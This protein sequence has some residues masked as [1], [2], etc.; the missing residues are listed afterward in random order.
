MELNNK[1]NNILKDHKDVLAQYEELIKELNVNDTINENIRLKEKTKNHE[2]ELYILRQKQSELEKEII[3]LKISLKDQMINEKR[4]IVGI[5]KQKTHIYFQDATNRNTN[6]L[7]ALEISASKR[8]NDIKDIANQEFNETNKEIIAKIG[9]IRRELELQINSRKAKYALKEEGVL[10]EIEN[11]YEKLGN[12][13]L[14]NAILEKKKKHNNLEVKIGLNWINKIGVILLL[15]GVITA[16]QYTYSNW[17]DNYMKGISGF[18]LGIVLL[19]VGE[20]FNRKEKNLFALGLIGG[21]IGILYLSVFSSYF[22][23]DIL[24][25]PVSI[26]ISVLITVVS[27]T[28]SQRYKSMTICG[29][30]LIGGYLPF[31]SYSF[32]EGLTPE[33]IY[34]SMGYLF[35]LNILV[36]SISLGRRW[37]YINY[38]SF[39]LNTICLIYLVFAAP[40]KMISI[41]YALL[42]FIMYLVI[43]LAYPIGAKV[44]LKLADIILLALNT[45]I[46]CLLVY[47]LIDIAG[48]N[49]YK[50]LLA[51]T[52]AIVYLGLGQFVYK[53]A[54]QE[55]SI[56][57]LFYITA[58]TFTI[59]V[60]P[61]QFGVKWASLGWLIEG[62][63]LITYA[64]KNKEKKIELSGWIILG[65][66]TLGFVAVDLLSLWNFEYL[67]IRYSSLTL[68]FI[69]ALSIYIKQLSDSE[70]FKYSTKGKFLTYF[71]YITVINA[72]LFLM[73]LTPQLYHKYVD[74]SQYNVFYNLISVAL[75]TG[76]FAYL[77]TKIKVIQDKVINGISIALYIFVDIIGFSMCF[78]NIGGY[79]YSSYKII[80]IVILITYNIFV[81]FNLKYL[82]F[83]LLKNRRFSIEYYPIPLAIYIL[84]SATGLVISQF[85]IG[86][87]NLIVSIFFIVMSFA[88]IVSGFKK[89]YVILRRFGLGLSIISTGKLFVF[90]L[91]F[92]ETGGKIIAYFCFGLVL[93]GISY[94]Y[95]RLRNS[96]DEKTVE[97]I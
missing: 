68:G 7:E 5:S 78:Y 85:N 86:N 19:G 71:K 95:H 49:S 82:I 56:Q 27:L 62:L 87:I 17:F 43:T 14:S 70:I 72:W 92:L 3:N 57:A 54:S 39:M 23:L 21:G 81:F 75:I 94:I 33:A 41:F 91:M 97:N 1:I 9:S 46:N 16:M 65:L 8:L 89:S 58:L 79:A 53:S 47:L 90:D 59:L 28:L 20:W 80:A 73:W 12:E 24:S 37:I 77:I 69:Y 63:L 61:F 25:M 44:K 93:I 76:L 67:L 50:G 13:E 83:K 74:I 29:I 52:Y 2:E 35:I 22:M 84:G 66:C 38:L 48:Y 6:K 60:I 55:K 34:I 96:F 18:L 64:V 15:L 88:Y 32:F 26:L 30:S 10:E 11:E 31:F 36:L 42:T 40:N 45:F 51:L 4:D